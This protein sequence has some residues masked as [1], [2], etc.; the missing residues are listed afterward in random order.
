MSTP[1]RSTSIRMLLGRARLARLAFS[2]VPIV[3]L[4][5][6][7]S[8]PGAPRQVRKRKVV[9]KTSEIAASCLWVHG[10][11]SAANGN[12]TMRVWKIGTHHVFGILS[13]PGSLDR[14]PNDSL[15][16]ELP[17]NVQRAFK[18]VGTYIYADFEICPLK[19]E[20]TG[21]MQDACIESA[22]NLVTTEP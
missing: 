12:P 10:R 3:A 15:E 6:C 22:K 8:S 7:I 11:L 20:R 2:V 9:C 4:A 18:S 5:A 17:P 14:N 16:P 13:G 19:P 21:E 1:T